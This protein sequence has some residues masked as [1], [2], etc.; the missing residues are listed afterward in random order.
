MFF[1][2][3]NY[4]GILLIV[5]IKYFLLF[6]VKYFIFYLFIL[7]CAKFLVEEETTLSVVAT[8]AW[9]LRKCSHA[10]VLILI[11]LISIRSGIV[12]AVYSK[13]NCQQFPSLLIIHLVVNMLIRNYFYLYFLLAQYVGPVLTKFYRNEVLIHN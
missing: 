8:I 1:H 4:F 3:S 5:L 12:H 11:F 7:F 6:W 9:G 2:S 10:A 13:Y